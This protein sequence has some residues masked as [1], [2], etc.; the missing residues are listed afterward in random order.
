MESETI[1][2][3]DTKESVDTSVGK[4]LGMVGEMSFKNYKG[5]TLANTEGKE[6]SSSI[7]ASDFYLM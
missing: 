2:N 5:L 4:D 3:K 1:F 6:Q 7:D